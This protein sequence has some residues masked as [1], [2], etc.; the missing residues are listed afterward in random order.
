MSTFIESAACRGRRPQGL[1]ARIHHPRSEL[2]ARLLKERRVVRFL[3]APDGFGKT[4]L[5]YSYADVVFSFSHVFW[6]N[7][8]SP[9]FLRD[10]DARTIGEDI[11]RLDEAA[12]LVVF[13]DLP[14]LDADRARLLAQL[15]D[16][17]LERGMEVLATC[18]PSCDVYG[19]LQQD[20]LILT[21][22]DLLL[23]P[24]DLRISLRGER[25][26][27]EEAQ[28]WPRAERIAC[29]RWKDDGESDL[30]MGVRREELPS[31]L[32]LAMLVLLLMRRGEVDDLRVFLAAGEERVSE[33]LGLLERGYPF[34]GIV[35]RDGSFSTA[36][37]AV[38]SLAAA[39]GSLFDALARASAFRERDALAGRIADALLAR[40]EHERAM[41]LVL[42]FS[43]KVGAG[44]WLVCRG[45]RYV[46]DGKAL[47]VRDAYDAVARSAL[48]NRSA[49]NAVVA[50][51]ARV[52][53][54]AS[55]AVGFAKRTAFNQAADRSDA[56]LSCVLL[57]R[58]GSPEQAG[59]AAGLIEALL[60]D[61][62]ERPARDG[63]SAPESWM[64]VDAL[65]RLALA[66]RKG[67][68][69]G[70]RVWRDVRETS[71]R[72][73][74]APGEPLTNALLLGAAWLF[75]ALSTG[76]VRM[77]ASREGFSGQE[78]ASDAD[79]VGFSDVAVL[80]GFVVSCLDRGAEDEAHVGWCE[81]T[82]FSAMER[83]ARVTSSLPVETPGAS[84]LARLRRAEVS[85]LAQQGE[86]RK[87]RALHDRQMSAF[88][89][90]H[91][92]AFRDDARTA[93][94]T[95]SSAR[96]MAPMLRV[97]LFGSLEVRLGE[98]PV[99]PEL[100]KQ[101]KVKTLLA[102]LVLARGR[103]VTR[104]RLAQMLWPQSSLSASRKNLYAT[105]AKLV[106]A[107]SV[108]G[109][110]PYLVRDQRGCRINAR[111]VT[112]D[113]SEFEA[114]CRTLLFGKSD[115]MEW[116]S[117][118]ASVEES[119]AD[120]LMPTEADN[121]AIIA[122]RDKYHV[123]LVDA[124]LAAANRLVRAGEAQGA[125]W[126]AREALRRD[127]T[128]E[129]AYS[130]LMEAQLAAGQRG[131]ALDTFFACKRYLSDELGIDPSPRIVELYRSIIEVEESFA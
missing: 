33:M 60:L 45:W 111:L 104:D 78:A 37:L 117:L 86:Y 53:G 38:S 98:E 19:G 75:E 108:E 118:Y 102:M 15:F 105:W 40:G 52:L 27:P 58:D 48:K 26:D 125:L 101:Q 82:A 68:S 109:A 113:V 10:L 42:A 72:F 18:A 41:E 106:R 59:R 121:E 55:G 100:L 90:T 14:R 62:G 63:E 50:W 4:S 65:A 54:D 66:F 21:G 25:L 1:V 46:A 64:D 71:A 94:A 97:N 112:S 9:C 126:F 119:F 128:R 129:D 89:E 61:E 80:S 110:C 22:Y 107:L 99:D 85:V 116:E 43:T 120:E 131:S 123:Q 6:V 74:S 114:I 103:E 3:V 69:R 30:V 34:L 76:G 24:A 17:L 122:L 130:A 7:A 16:G 51:A 83:A 31:D 57:L 115:E 49:C 28:R 95:N 88:Y 11:G 87:A 35:L 79:A 13:E 56:M 44:S 20:R 96:V 8:R 2:V 12:S 84:A 127:R 81:L 29:L 36:S 70:M 93:P 32:M 124:L 5:A 77:L 23:T 47:P 91:P 67:A 73:P 39:A 92:N